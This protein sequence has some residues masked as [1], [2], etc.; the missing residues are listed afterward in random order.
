MS[1]HPRYII[2]TPAD[3]LTIPQEK[4]E[5]ALKDF[6]SWI[7]YSRALAVVAKEISE[8][9]A[10]EVDVSKFVW[11]DDGKHDMIPV[12]EIKEPSKGAGDDQQKH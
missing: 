10:L 6:Y 12:F 7:E 5:H 8:L 1:E 2:K 3:F 11:I 4:L 9:A